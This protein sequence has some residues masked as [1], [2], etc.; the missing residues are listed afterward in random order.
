M[1]TRGTQMMFKRI[2]TT[3]DQGEKQPQQSCQQCINAT[4]ASATTALAEALL[5]V[6]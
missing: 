3:L 2:L 5:E 1:K 6:Q 4:A